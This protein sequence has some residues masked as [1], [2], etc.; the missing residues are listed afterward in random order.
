MTWLTPIRPDVQSCDD[1]LAI[2]LNSL[3]QPS[4]TA[5]RASRM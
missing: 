2:E 3:H 5:P 4:F 1:T